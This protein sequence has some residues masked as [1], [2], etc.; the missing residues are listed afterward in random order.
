MERGITNEITAS[1]PNQHSI[2]PGTYPGRSRVIQ[3]H[4]H[5]QNCLYGIYIYSTAAAMTKTSNI[6]YIYTCDIGS[7]GQSSRCWIYIYIY[8][9]HIGS[10]GHGSCS[11]KDIYVIKTVWV[12]ANVIIMSR[13]QHRSLWPSLAK[14]ISFIDTELLYIGF[15]WSS[16]LCSSMW[17]GPPD[18]I[19]EEF[20]LTSPAVF[21]MSGSS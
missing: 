14:A 18:Y 16:C 7:L 21:C 10:F 19:T 4:L 17:R 13:C 12:T 5:L 8:I 6:A 11:C 3:P 20:V 15:S 1:S 2:Q 9:C